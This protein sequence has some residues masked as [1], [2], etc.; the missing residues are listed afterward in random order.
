MYIED[1]EQL[2]VLKMIYNFFGRLFILQDIR[3]RNV[4]LSCNGAIIGYTNE[5]HFEKLEVWYYIG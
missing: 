1:F 5:A 3:T 4:N 2:Y